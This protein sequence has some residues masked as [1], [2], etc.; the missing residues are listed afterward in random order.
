MAGSWRRACTWLVAVVSSHAVSSIWALESRRPSTV[1]VAERGH[2][3]VTALGAG[4][5]DCVRSC[6]SGPGGTQVAQCGLEGAVGGV[7]VDVL[8]GAVA[9]CPGP[10]SARSRPKTSTH[11]RRA[12]SR[13]SAT[14]WAM[15][16][17][18]AAGHRDVG[19]GGAGVLAEEEVAG[20]GGLALGA[21]D[22]GGVGELDVLAHVAGRERSAVPARAV[23][24]GGSGCRRASM[25]VTVQVSRLATPR[26]RSLRRVATRSPTPIRSPA[27]VTT[28]TTV[29][30]VAG[31]DEPVADRAVERGDLFAGVGHHQHPVCG[32][33]AA[34]WRRRGRRAPA[35]RSASVGWTTIW[36]ARPP[37]CRS[38][39]PGRTP[40]AHRQAEVGVLA[41]RRTGAPCRGHARPRVGPAGGEVEDAAAAD[42]GEL[43]PVADERDPGPVSSAR[44]SR[45]RAVSWSSIPAS[46]TSSRSPRSQHGVRRP[47][48][49]ARG[50]SGR[51]R[52][53]ASRAGGPARPRRTRR[54]RSRRPATWAAFRVGVTT[55]IRWP[56]SREQRLGGGE[57]G[58][59]ARAGRALDDQQLRRCRRAR[60]RPLAARRPDP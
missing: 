15:L 26:S 25:P 14:R 45:A 40:G 2:E 30:D 17:L 21:V 1:R 28:P 5:G 56:C 38:T 51:R 57:G 8:G 32:R 39:S 49:R 31:G 18:A 43:V 58:G 50:S 47:G 37:G 41:G 29:I 11:C 20:V 59:L 36:P 12:S 33:L 53:S 13:F 54:R 52:P 23:A 10:R 46:S 4:Q 34:C 27:P 48:S 3:V 42:G 7:A 9:A 22:G 60:R 16:S 19:R 35:V 44:V 6:S 55:T 24:C